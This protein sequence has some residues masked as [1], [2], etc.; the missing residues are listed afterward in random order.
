M[1]CWCMAVLS[2][3]LTDNDPVQVD[4]GIE[5]LWFFD[6]QVADDVLLG[7]LGG[8]FGVSYFPLLLGV[9]N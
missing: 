4:L 2:G 5:L 9:H 7:V 6:V 1:C 8:A 3:V